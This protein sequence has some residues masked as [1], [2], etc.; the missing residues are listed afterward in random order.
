MFEFGNLASLRPLRKRIIKHVKA[1]Q[2]ASRIGSFQTGRLRH[3]LRQAVRRLAVGV[4]VPAEG[5]GRAMVR[6]RLEG[7]QTQISGLHQ[8]RCFGDRGGV[9]VAATS[10]KK[11]H[12]KLRIKQLHYQSFIRKIWPTL[13]H[14]R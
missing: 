14:S 10:R 5:R 12:N 11:V 3:Q 1:E 9:T 13:F 2:P 7:G 6:K 8:P 4:D